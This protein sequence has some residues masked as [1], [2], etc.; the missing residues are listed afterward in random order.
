M[1]QKENSLMPVILVLIVILL[2]MTT[3]AFISISEEKDDEVEAP[4]PPNLYSSSQFGIGTGNRLGTYYPTGKVLAEYF[5]SRLDSKGGS[6]KA[7]ETSGSINNIELLQTKRVQFAMIEARVAKE[8]FQKNPDL[9]VI[10]PLWLDVVQL[11]RPPKDVV[12]NYVFPGKIKGYMGQKNSSPVRTC[13]E[14]FDA[15]GIKGRHK[16]DIPTNSVLK[17]IADGRLGFAMIQAGIPNKSVSDA[18]VWNDCGLVSFTSE[19][20]KFILDSVPSSIPFVLPADYYKAGQPEINTIGLPNLLI[21]TSEIS[22]QLVEYVTEMLVDGCPRLK[23]RYKALETVPTDK[24]SVARVVEETGIPLHDG[25]K[26]WLKKKS[27]QEA[28]K[29]GSAR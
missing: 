10:W 18:L 12:P 15:L 4:E 24:V 16:V 2:G 14:I 22:P 21:T 17:F 29:G 3:L 19:Q 13:E 7:F 1:K 28:E 25:T 11:L 27:N 20:Q 26:N 8:A 9:R 5:N 23:G 6:F